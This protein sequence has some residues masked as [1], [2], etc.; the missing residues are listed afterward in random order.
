MKHQ[1]DSPPL[2]QS[3]AK[4]LGFSLAFALAVW[5]SAWGGVWV[6]GQ[7]AGIQ[8]HQLLSQGQVFPSAPLPQQT[9]FQPIPSEGNQTSSE[10]V[11]MPMTSGAPPDA[12]Q[13]TVPV[14]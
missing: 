13:G 2:H 5:D 7:D 1:P 8:A 10:P 9:Q 14:F 11:E 6:N 4:Q 3:L 12:G